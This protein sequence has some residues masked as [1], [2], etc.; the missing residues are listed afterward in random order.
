MR[1]VIKQMFCLIITFVVVVLFNGC[2][3]GGKPRSAAVSSEQFKRQGNIKANKGD[4]S[5]AIADYD[6][7][8]QENTTNGSAYN[9]RGK[10]KSEIG[11]LDGAIADYSRVIE[12]EPNDAWLP[13]WARGNA[14]SRKGDWDGAIADYDRSIQAN[15]K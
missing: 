3:T 15:Q 7:A 10:A 1:V 13:Y 6:R 5:D 4:Y 12:L 14:K 9:G 2:A 11:D 8:I